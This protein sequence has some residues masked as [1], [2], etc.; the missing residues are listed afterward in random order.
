MSKIKNMEDLREH[1]LETLE[2]LAS[3]QIDTA[4]AGVTGKLCEGVIATVKSQLEYA[5]MLNQEPTIPFMSS[6][7]GRLIEGSKPTKEL[8]HKK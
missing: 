6:S 5:R 7:T 2:K 1:A 4:E 3:G 8:P